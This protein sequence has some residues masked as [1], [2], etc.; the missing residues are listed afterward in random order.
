MTGAADVD[1][2]YQVGVLV[3][4]FVRSGKDSAIRGSVLGVRDR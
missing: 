3:A 2:R 4:I 1:D